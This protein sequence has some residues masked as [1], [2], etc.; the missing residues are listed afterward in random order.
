MN[1]GYKKNSN[2]TNNP[3]YARM[4]T[5]LPMC[6]DDLPFVTTQRITTRQADINRKFATD[7]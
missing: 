2:V 6:F 5:S 1:S 4:S 7:A 3:Q